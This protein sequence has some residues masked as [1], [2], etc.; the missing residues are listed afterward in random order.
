M[1]HHAA[2]RMRERYG[3]PLT[4]E[5]QQYLLAEVARASREPC[6]R[7]AL[8]EHGPGSKQRWLVGVPAG[9]C[10]PTNLVLHVVVAMYPA[11]ALVT[12]LPPN[13]NGHR[14]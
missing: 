3:L 5:L 1:S 10:A 14:P 2:L 7:A 13:S 12:V 11:P 4:P 8:L 6:K 9:L